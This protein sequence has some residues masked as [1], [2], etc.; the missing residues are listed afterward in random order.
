LKNEMI[1]AMPDTFEMLLLRRSTQAT[2]LR[3]YIARDN[4]HGD[5]IEALGISLIKRVFSSYELPLVGRLQTNRSW[6]D[7]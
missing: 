4:D 2:H 1:L 3:T 5:M 7:C 6:V